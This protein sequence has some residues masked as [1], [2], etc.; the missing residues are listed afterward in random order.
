MRTKRPDEAYEIAALSKGLVVLEALEGT[1]F[2]PVPVQRI[3]DRTGLP[4][5][6]VDR[7]LKTLR[8]RGYAVQNDRG[9]WSVG[10]RFLR[11]AAVAAQKI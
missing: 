10:Q 8:L 4:R 6:I 2:E 11:L 9:E 5:D 1:N 7:S 3:I